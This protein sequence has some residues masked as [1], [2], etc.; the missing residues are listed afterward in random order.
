MAP[1]KDSPE[2]PTL[3]CN[4]AV[5]GNLADGGGGVGCV[6]ADCFLSSIRA[7]RRVLL[8]V[9]SWAA[10]VAVSPPFKIKLTFIQMDLQERPDDVVV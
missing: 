5:A 9:T 7:R 6:V 8:G 1:K 3:E 10:V 2:V 4:A